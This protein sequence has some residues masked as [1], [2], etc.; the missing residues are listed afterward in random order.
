[1]SLLI[2]SEQLFQHWS[3][4][5]DDKD[6]RYEGFI[7]QGKIISYRYTQWQLQDIDISEILNYQN[8]ELEYSGPL[9]TKIN[10]F[11]D[12]LKNINDIP[13]IV[14]IPVDRS[15]LKPF[16]EHKYTPDIKWEAADG[17]HRLHLMIK[18]GVKKIKCYI[19]KGII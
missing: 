13:P 2:D 15:V 5:Q 6:P 9:I 17:V 4:C 8:S 14:L 3:S 12:R 1:M 10:S 16:I 11:I 18:L 19:P 7:A